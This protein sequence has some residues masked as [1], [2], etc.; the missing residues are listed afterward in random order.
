MEKKKEKKRKKKKPVFSSIRFDMNCVT[1]RHVTSRGL[2]DADSCLNASR[3][4]KQTG[5]TEEM[6]F[7]PF[8]RIACMQPCVDVLPSADWTFLRLVCVEI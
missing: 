1:S 7:I 2:I 4:G 8:F 5:E 6:A 3:G